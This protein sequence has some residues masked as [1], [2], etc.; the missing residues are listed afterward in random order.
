MEIKHSGRN[1]QRD[2]WEYWRQAFNKGRH[3]NISANVYHRLMLRHAIIRDT[4]SLERQLNPACKASHERNQCDCNPVAST[5]ECSTK[6]KADT[7]VGKQEN[8]EKELCPHLQ[9]YHIATTDLFVEKAIA[10]LEHD[11]E[12]YMKVGNKRILL[13]YIITIV[14][15]I[16]SLLF[17]ID[18]DLCDGASSL[19]TCPR[20]TYEEILSKTLKGISFY[21]MLVTLAVALWRSG[22]ANLQQAERLRER[23]HALRQGRLFVHLKDGALTIDEL[24]KAF[25]WNAHKENGFDTMSAE[26][27][28]P[29]SGL[30]QKLQGI[31]R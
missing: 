1:D 29:L 21:A 26:A 10:Y 25:N 14:G 15:I 7:E 13:G 2:C 12:N 6:S 18:K 20:F 24:D 17:M 30:F 22:K 28:A 23:R 5:H 11:Y 9:S 19:A 4:V 8:A 16:T 27:N 31:F 3:W